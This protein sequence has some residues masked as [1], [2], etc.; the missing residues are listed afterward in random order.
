MRSTLHTCIL[1]MKE[2]NEKTE[3]TNV[4]TTSNACSQVL[5]ATVAQ[6]LAY[7]THDLEILGLI[8]SCC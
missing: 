2:D 5:Y 7:L 6:E 4:F 1:T 3:N 8:P